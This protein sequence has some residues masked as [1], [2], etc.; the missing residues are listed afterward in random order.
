MNQKIYRIRGRTLNEAY[1][2]T[3]RQIGPDALVLSTREVR[4]GGFFGWGG[5]KMIELTVAAPEPLPQRRRS[6]P[7]QHY[8]AQTREGAPTSSA[9][10]GYYENL[11]RDAQRRMRTAPPA[12]P[13]PAAAAGAAIVPF[14]KTAEEHTNPQ[15]LQ[16]ELREI[17]EMLRVLYME[18]PAT[19][20]PPVIAD[21]YR[22]FLACGMSRKSAA[23]LV[24]GL[25]QPTP[26]GVIGE[27]F[28]PEACRQRLSLEIR[29]HIR[30]TGGVALR[31]GEPRVVVFCGPTGVGKTTTLAKIAAHFV[32]TARASLAFL[33]ADTFRVA[34]IEQLR[35]YANIVG[36]PLR[37]ISDA[38]EAREARATF[39][40]YDLILVDTAGGSPFNLEQLAELRQIINALD[41]YETYLVISAN[42]PLNDLRHVITNFGMLAPSAVVVT[43]LDETR[44]YGTL[45]SSAMESG[46]PLAYFGVGQRVPEDLRVAS[47]DLVADLLLQ[48]KR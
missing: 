30:T 4:E 33:S 31:A 25:L 3:R 20:F 45:V 6:T 5:R 26:S 44:Q 12:A 47:T 14:P 46:L 18:H 41:P 28:T 1:E 23:T 10:L 7:E 15:D 21:L 39:A 37:V 22:N 13:Q 32:L 8:Q 11:I 48:G 34:A 29:R 16:R 43:K 24:S 42:T 36:A 35:V 2:K 27:P 40:G 38:Q 9:Q 19:G 17:H